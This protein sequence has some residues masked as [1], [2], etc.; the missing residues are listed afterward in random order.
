MSGFT[1]LNVC[2]RRH[3]PIL[4]LMDP[5]TGRRWLR[6]EDLRAKLYVHEMVVPAAGWR[7]WAASED[8]LGPLG[9]RLAALGVD[10]VEV[11]RFVDAAVA[12]PG[13]RALAALDA[14]V[15]MAASLVESSAIARGPAARPLVTAALADL[16][17]AEGD[18]RGPPPLSLSDF[19]IPRA[20]HAADA[21]L[22]VPLHYWSAFP[23]AASDD[24]DEQLIVQGM[25]AIRVLGTRADAA[26][27]GDEPAEAPVVSPELQRALDEPPAD[28][29]GELRR[30]AR[31]T[32]RLAPA[33]LTFATILAGLAAVLAILPLAALLGFAGALDG[34]SARGAAIGLALA[35]PVAGLAARAL[36]DLAAARIGRGLEHRLRVAILDKIPRLRDQYYATR[37][38]A[39]LAGRAHRLQQVREMPRALAQLGL[40]ALEIGVAA[41][42]MIWLAPATGVAAVAAIAAGMGLYFLSKPILSE[43]AS[44]MDSHR[45]IAHRPVWDSLYGPAPI[46]AH[47]NEPSQRR[48]QEDSLTTFAGA[49]RKHGAAEIIFSSLGE[50]CALG[51]VAFVGLRL[52][53]QGDPA[54]ALV[55]VFWATV[56]GWRLPIF[57]TQAADVRSRRQEVGYILEPLTELDDEEAQSTA[58]VDPIQ[59]TGPIAIRFESVALKVG[60]LTILEG[61]DLDIPAG[62]K[63]A[64]IGR[65]GAGKTSLVGLILGWHRPSAGKILVNGQPYDAA[66]GTALRRAAVWVDPS[67]HIFNRSLADNVGYGIAAGADRPTATVLDEA[68]LGEVV[69]RLSAEDRS[70]RAD[71]GTLVRESDGSR[72]GEGGRL[73]SGGESQRV[74]FARAM[75]KR[76]P[77]LVVLDEPF[78]GLERERRLALLDRARTLWADATFVCAVH[79]MEVAAKFDR[80]IVLENGRVMEDGAPA[81]LLARPGS[82]FAARW[83]AERRT[84]A[85]LLAG[86]SWRRLVVEAGQVRELPITVHPVVQPVVQPDEEPDDG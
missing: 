15:R 56:I 41:A 59:F 10:G 84:R 17:P 13:W 7:E 85:E 73:L 74:R 47:G 39:G 30:L 27:A 5:G 46:R 29:L 32:G 79:D 60:G 40:A 69:E 50:L 34:E 49:A 24:G 75:K 63:V 80:V 53:G 57:F 20:G 23:T 1:H 21:A 67:V 51:L 19:P 48:V 55:G 8:F 4:Q 83:D 70:R 64:V 65:S 16:C 38:N 54:R 62:A 33:T 22:F 9:G 25:V 35:L 61:L 26:T 37:P 77:R 36:A 14:S 71:G 86:A 2:W 58:A 6:F 68:L 11:K 12:A 81:E 28:S 76:D 72:L 42:A 82:L 18:H 78:R 52:A 45:S 43:S 3:G 44:R 31:A 66:T